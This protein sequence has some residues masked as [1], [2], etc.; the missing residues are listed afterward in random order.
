MTCRL[1]PEWQ[2]Q[3]AILLAWP[4]ADTDWQRTLD[5]IHAV[6]IDLIKQITRFQRVVLVV[7]NSQ[8]HSQ[9][10]QAL[11]SNGIVIEKIV[12]IEAAYNDT[13]LRDTGP[14]A[15]MAQDQIELHDFRF[16]GWGGK[17]NAQLDDQLCAQLFKHPAFAPQQQSHP[18]FLEG[19]SI[20]TDGAGTLLTTSRCLLTRTR[21]PAMNR[22]DYAQLFQR[23]FQIERVLWIEHGELEGDDTDS[24]ID[25][26]ARFCDPQT[27]AYTACNDESDTHFA[28]LAQLKTELQALKQNDGAPYTLVPLEI[29][30]AKT[31]QD[32]ER[33]P[34]SYANFLI[35]NQAVLV[36]VYDDEMDGV[37]MRQLAACF[38]ERDII[39]IKANAI[40]QQ[41]GSLHCLTM[42]LPSGSLQT[43]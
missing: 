30:R 24:H 15:C 17:F 20:D 42:Q 34:A 25:M 11:L 37:A 35:I 2:Q 39:A 4:H 28:S 38:P 31:N 33:L 12:F 41:G 18:I 3:D 26:L 43:I 7:P 40:I 8:I 13:W 19:G 10:K 32:G 22:H 27:I 5:A 9:A 16:N 36:P 21:N 29:P 14:L 23:L 6:Y 1:L